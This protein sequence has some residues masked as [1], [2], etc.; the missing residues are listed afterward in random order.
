MPNYYQTLGVS[1]DVDKR[2][3]KKAYRK[4][5]RQYHPD[6]NPGDKS[7]E[8]KFKQINEAYEVL[9]DDDDRKKYDRYGDKWRQ[10]D[11]IDSQFGG[12]AGGPFTWTWRGTGRPR[13]SASSDLFGG[14][15]DFFG[16]FGD[17]SGR[18]GDSTRTRVEGEVEV[19][20]EE[21]FSGAKRNVT[22]TSNRGER[23][24]EVTIP[25]GVKTGS[26][27]RVSPGGGQELRLKVTVLPDERFK[28]V[29]DNLEVEADLPW[30]DV[31]LGGEVEVQT[32]NGKVSLKV[33][34]ESQNG[35]RF[36]LKGKGMPKLGSKGATGDL[37]VVLRPSLSKGLT[38]EQ[39]DLVTKL[40]QSQS[41]EG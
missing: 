29:G 31:V 22:V 12:A 20:L 36:R 27:V 13:E 35:Q 4:L 38:D 25:A 16:G 18:R 23:R 41:R 7:A 30:E 3:I 19:T 9:S 14:F 21:A 33:P 26:V 32:M 11:R 10:A 17:R 24:L 2:E 8:T 15:E 40:K 1:K 28:R 6:L 5:A 37:Y 39:R 34:P